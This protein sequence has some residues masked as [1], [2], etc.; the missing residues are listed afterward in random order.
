MSFLYV[1][2][3][4]LPS[5]FLS[6]LSSF[7]RLADSGCSIWLLHHSVCCYFAVHPLVCPAAQTGECLSHTDITD[8]VNLRLLSRPIEICWSIKVILFWRVWCFLHLVSLRVFHVVPFFIC[9]CFQEF[10]QFYQDKKTREKLDEENS[11]NLMNGGMHAVTLFVLECLVFKVSLDADW[12]SLFLRLSVLFC[13][14]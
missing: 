9:L 7:R 8:I 14:K 10:F 11:V 6:C 1:L 12:W 5:L 2:I 13:R 3:S 4:S